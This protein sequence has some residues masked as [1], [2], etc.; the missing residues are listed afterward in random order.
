MTQ[1]AKKQEELIDMFLADNP[2]LEE[3]TDRL[4]TFNVFRALKIEN[5]EIRHS[6]VLGWLLDPSGSHGL[7]DIIL[8]RVLSNILLLSDKSIDHI[9]PAQVELKDFYDV[10][11]LREWKN[12]DLLVVDRINTIEKVKKELKDKKP[13]IKIDFDIVPKM[14]SVNYMD[15]VLCLEE[16]QYDISMEEAKRLKELYKTI[17]GE[18][19][20]VY[21]KEEEE[22]PENSG[23]TIDDVRE[24]AY[25]N[26]IDYPETDSVLQMLY[27]NKLITYP[28]SESTILPDPKD[29]DIG[30]KYYREIIDNCLEQLDLSDNEEYIIDGYNLVR[31][32]SYSDGAHYAI[33]PTN[34]R[35]E[36]ELPQIHKFIYEFIM[37]RFIKG[38]S[39]PKIWNNYMCEVQFENDGIVLPE[40]MESTF[41]QE[42]DDFG[43][44]C[45]DNPSKLNYR[46]LEEDEIPMV[47][48]GTKIPCVTKIDERVVVV[49]PPDRFSKEEL[50]KFL[51]DEQLGTD[52]TR[53]II[54]QKLWNDNLLRGDPPFPTVLGKRIIDAIKLI[55]IKLTETRLTRE[56]EVN[57]EKV[58]DGSHEVNDIKKDLRIEIINVVNAKLSD[59]EEIGNNIAFFGNCQQC[60]GRMKLVSY[61]RQGQSSFFLAC[62]KDDCNYTMPI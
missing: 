28:R 31:M 8:R 6:N 52:A 43:Y 7:G 27:L 46:S 29:D 1:N 12:I 30:E 19:I 34:V 5:T 49:V 32:G 25:G 57:M 17:E 15:E 39:F 54:L 36:S 42:I 4:A 35:L 62:E 58:K 45:V 10:E 56:F 21:K 55:N 13:V 33:H 59:M 23:L 61:V 26:G 14:P 37:K 44:E 38:F 50:Y 24:W 48:V 11:V 47:D 3:L 53:S 51:R 20:R 9:S 22:E 18:I 41:W 16:D 2:E 60:D 40:T